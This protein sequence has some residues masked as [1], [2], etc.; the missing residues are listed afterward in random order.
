MPM[1]DCEQPFLRDTLPQGTTQIIVVGCNG[2]GGGGEHS[3]AEIH[4]SRR[5][6][7]IYLR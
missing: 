2:W 1:G 5:G 3:A 7:I 6:E 4:Y